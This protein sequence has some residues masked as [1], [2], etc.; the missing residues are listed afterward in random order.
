MQKRVLFA[1]LLAVLAAAGCNDH[2]NPSAVR[3][4][5]PPAGPRGV[6][7]VTGDTEVQLNWLANTEPDV[8]GYRIYESPCASGPGCPYDRIGTTGATSFV[9]SQL[10][11]GVTRYYAV[12]AFDQAGN[13]SEL[14]FNTVFDTPRPE[15]FGLSLTNYLVDPAHAGYDFSAYA[16]RAFDATRTDIYFGVQDT[17]RMVFALFTDT[18][19]QDA[20]YASSLDAVDFAPTAGW[21][22]AGKV[23]AVIGHC[24]VV[25]IVD[26]YAKFRVTAVSGTQVTVDWAYQI[27]P[28]NRELKARREPSNDR[29]VRRQFAL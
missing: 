26:H 28:G 22:P 18:D 7:S 4:V 16:V 11:N 13:E 17:T 9:V 6:Y 24:Y 27:D 3:D 14:S 10:T 29:R 25:R 5:T 8:A 20:G 19:I 12:A 2:N 1:A 21:S 23:E 15:G